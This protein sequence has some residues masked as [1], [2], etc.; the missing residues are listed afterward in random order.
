[1]D[2]K[3]CDSH[4]HS[5]LPTP[6][7]LLGM[8]FSLYCSSHFIPS[9]DPTWQ[10][11]LWLLCYSQTL[12]VILCL[13]IF[14]PFKFSWQCNL[15]GALM[16]EHGYLYTLDRRTAL[17][18]LGKVVLFDLGH[19]FGKEVHGVVGKEGDTGLAS[20]ISGVTPGGQWGDRCSS[21]ITLTF[22]A[23]QFKAAIIGTNS[24]HYK[25]KKTLC[26]AFPTDEANL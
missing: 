23:M 13:C 21:Q 16:A 22:L 18:Y 5:S 8:F 9:H 10:E 1:M 11:G 3:V 24:S 25:S 19:S 14:F 7:I 12:A 15:F 2:F 4:F 20:Q 6:L 17:L 26:L